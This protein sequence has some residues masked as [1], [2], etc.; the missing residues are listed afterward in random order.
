[1]NCCNSDTCCLS[2]HAKEKDH[3]PTPANV[4][5]IVCLNC[6]KKQPYTKL[7]HTKQTDHDTTCE[8]GA[9]FAEYVCLECLVFDAND[10]VFHCNECKSCR[11]GTQDKFRHCSKCGY[12][13]E[14][15]DSA[16]PHM[17]YEGSTTCPVCLQEFSSVDPLPMLQFQCGHFIHQDCW[18]PQIRLCPFCRQTVVEPI[19]VQREKSGP[20]WQQWASTAWNVTSES[21]LKFWK[22]LVYE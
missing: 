20:G 17:C 12:C 3:I 22:D 7:E 19:T 9:R 1:V 18:A 2:C 10:V 16:R 13:I 15:N 6:R 5:H 21:C 11:L 8:C 14:I 4:T